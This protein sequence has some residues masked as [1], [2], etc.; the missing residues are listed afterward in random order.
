M[1]GLLAG[2]EDRL[3]A[4]VLQVGDGGLVTHMTGPED[5]GWRLAQ[6][7]AVRRK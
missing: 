6:P 2:V 3:R 7:A 4:Y 5:T 1:G